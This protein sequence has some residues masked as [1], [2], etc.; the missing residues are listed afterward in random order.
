MKILVIDSLVGNEY[1]TCLANALAEEIENEVH[2]I[3]PENREIESQ[4][5]IKIHYLSPTKQKDTGK[6]TKAYLY[7]KYLINLYN[8]IRIFRP[9]VV[10]YQFFRRKSEILFFKLLG[11]MKIKLVYTAHNVL[12]HEKSKIDYYLKSL[13]Y[14]NSHAIIVHS[15]FIRNKL[16]DNFKDINNKVMIIPHGNFDIYLPSKI[17]SQNEIRR[18]LNFTQKDDIILFFGFIREYKGLDVLLK[19]F[20]IAC[21]NNPNL[22]ML[23]AGMPF[24][25]EL[26]ERYLQMIHDSEY[27]DRISYYFDYVPK[28]DIVNYFIASDVVILPY[29]EIDHSGI[30]HLAYTFSRPVIATNVGDF[31]EVVQENKSGFILRNNTAEELA[32]VINLS[33]KDKKNLVE[34]GLNAKR[35]STSKYSWKDISLK[36]ISLYKSI[37]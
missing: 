13:V 3:V 33:F 6:F 17:I 15:A 5:N 7:L 24:S 21:I 28:D 11:I 22:K 18:G 30:I 2:L 23:I 29:K 31:S 9:D 19:S 34:M 36:T 4:N 26:E 25:T 16:I 8:F 35:L 20:N 10:H 37:I 14:R 32:K 1:S 27:Q 12:P